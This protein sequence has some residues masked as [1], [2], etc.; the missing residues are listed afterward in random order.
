VTVRRSAAGSHGVKA[1]WEK[2]EPGAV[3]IDSFDGTI[4]CFGLISTKLGTPIYPEARFLNPLD[5]FLRQSRTGHKGA[6]QLE[7]GTETKAERA[8]L[9]GPRRRWRAGTLVVM[10]ACVAHSKP[11]DDDPEPTTA[12]WFCRATLRV[13]IEGRRDST[14]AGHA[15]RLALALLVAE[16]VWEDPDF[17]LAATALD[18]QRRT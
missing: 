13:A 7:D 9:L 4:L 6:H 5:M 12:R 1:A 18:R 14:P 3:H 2:H 8:A 10:P 17:A 16:H 11:I 15:L